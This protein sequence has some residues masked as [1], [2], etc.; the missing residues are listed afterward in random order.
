M[1][2]LAIAFAA[3]FLPGIL[4]M[5]AALP[6]ASLLVAYAA[7]GFA[8]MHGITR[9]MHS[10]VIVLLTLYSGFVLLGWSGWPV[11]MMALLGLIDAAFDLRRRVAATRGPP[12]PPA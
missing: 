6:T 4:G 7:L 3:S 8:V 10:R 2:A 12:A 11:L 5:A 1:A 9:H